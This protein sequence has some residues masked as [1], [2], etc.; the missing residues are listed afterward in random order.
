[1]TRLAPSAPVVLVLTR[2]HPDDLA[3]RLMAGEDGD[4]W[5]V[6]NI[7]V[8][9]KENDLL[10]RKPGECLDSARQRTPQPWEQIRVAVCPEFGCPYTQ[11]TPHSTTAVFCRLSGHAMSNQCGSNKPTDPATFQA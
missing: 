5:T 1:M 3:G 8:E 11:A 10:G 2:W 7:P 4:R 6:L 9:A